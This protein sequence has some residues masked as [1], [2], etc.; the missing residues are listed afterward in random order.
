MVLKNGRQQAVLRAAVGLWRAESRAVGVH[1]RLWY[2]M[3]PD[4]SG[5][6]EKARS[7]R[8]EGICGVA[9]YGMPACV[10]EMSQ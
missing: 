2:V 7:A 6:H 1:R 3:S 8:G 9:K 5:R 10:R 4:P